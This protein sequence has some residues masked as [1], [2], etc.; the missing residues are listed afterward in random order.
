[1]YLCLL[2]QVLEGHEGPCG[3]IKADSAKSGLLHALLYNHGVAKFEA[4]CFE[5]AVKFFTASMDFAEVC[6]EH[7]CEVFCGM[8]FMR[9]LQ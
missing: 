8:V 6:C 3:V 5:V 4:K 9:I 7:H 1:V 2:P